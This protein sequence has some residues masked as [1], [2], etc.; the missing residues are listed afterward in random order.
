MLGMSAVTEAGSDIARTVPRR[1]PPRAPPEYRA[2]FGSAAATPIRSCGASWIA[3]V[4][5]GDVADDNPSPVRMSPGSI[6]TYDCVMAPS[7]SAIAPAT[8]VPTANRTTTSLPTML[9]RRPDVGAP[10]MKHAATGVMA[11]DSSMPE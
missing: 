8:A 6:H 9:M 2:T 5:T 3:V 11:N 7:A 10:I 1:A 4:V